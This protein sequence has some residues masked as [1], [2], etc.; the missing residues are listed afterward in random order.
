[1]YRTPEREPRRRTVNGVVWGLLCFMLQLSVLFW[2]W[3]V[4]AR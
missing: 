3:V 2:L 1:M 4:I